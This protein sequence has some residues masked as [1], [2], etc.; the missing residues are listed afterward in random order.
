MPGVVQHTR[1]SLRKAAA[2]A[3][4]ADLGGVILFGIPEGKDA[5]APGAKDPDSILN[6]RSPT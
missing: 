4:A 1:D 6:S 5:P 2:A 3:A